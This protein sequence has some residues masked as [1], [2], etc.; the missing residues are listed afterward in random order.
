M[1]NRLVVAFLGADNQLFKICESEG[2]LVVPAGS[3]LS[4]LYRRASRKAPAQC[5]LAFHIFVWLFFPVPFR[6]GRNAAYDR[7]LYCTTSS[8]IGLL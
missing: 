6:G 7:I 2:V 4:A 3:R 8:L 1:V 5:L